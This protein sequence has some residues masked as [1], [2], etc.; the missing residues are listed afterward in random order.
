MHL[1]AVTVNLSAIRELNFPGCNWAIILDTRFPKGICLRD[2]S[3]KHSDRHLN[4]RD[5]WEEKQ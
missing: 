1:T 2:S 3:P 4:K 5:L